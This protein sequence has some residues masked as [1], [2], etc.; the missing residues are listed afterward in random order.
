MGFYS[1]T[2]S[3]NKESIPNIYSGHP[4]A[5][6]TVYLLK[7]DGDH[8]KESAYCGYGVFGGVCAYALLAK[9]NLPETKELDLWD[10]TDELR[11][12]GIDLAYDHPQKIHTPLKFSFDSNANYNHLPPAEVCPLQGYC[13]PEES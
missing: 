6:R 4:D 1:W 10:D 3:D 12:L 13:Y 8:I 9:Q 11:C 7:P 2:T 5:G